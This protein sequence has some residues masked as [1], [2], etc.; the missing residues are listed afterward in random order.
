MAGIAIAVLIAV[1]LIILLVAQWRINEAM[2]YATDRIQ[3]ERESD[4]LD[5]RTQAA[6]FWQLIRGVNE[7]LSGY[8]GHIHF[9]AHLLPDGNPIDCIASVQLLDD[10]VHLEVCFPQSIMLLDGDS[11]WWWQGQPTDPAQ[12]PAEVLRA[13]LREV[14][15]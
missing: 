3:L 9:G 8:Q 11:T 7:V 2:R 12:A 6:K 13:A 4:Q 10:R 1:L 15:D 14:E 5:Q